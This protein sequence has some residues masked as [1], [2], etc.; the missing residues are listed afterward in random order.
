MNQIS[1]N[2]LFQHDF[3]AVNF[4]LL[5]IGIVFCGLVIICLY[6]TMLP[7]VLSWFARK[8]NSDTAGRSKNASTVN[9]K[10]SEKE[11]L[12]AIAVAYHMENS[13]PENDKITWD[14][15]PEVESAWQISGRMHNLASRS[16]IR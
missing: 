7:A 9:D 14:S 3:N 12:V 10:F 13:S 6:I 4:S 5:G 2:N 8:E 11:R 1:I 15:L 16:K